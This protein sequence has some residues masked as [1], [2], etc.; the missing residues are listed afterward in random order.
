MGTPHYQFLSNPNVHLDRSKVCS[1]ELKNKKSSGAKSVKTIQKDFEIRD[2]RGL[3]LEQA[4]ACCEP[5]AH[6]LSLTVPCQRPTSL[7]SVLDGSCRQ[8]LVCLS[9]I[10]RS[11]LRRCNSFSLSSSHSSFSSAYNIPKKPTRTSDPASCMGALELMNPTV[12]T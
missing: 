1:V 8:A 6:S 5:Q 2:P 11:L 12:T 7:R 4:G 3:Q 9:S 10:R